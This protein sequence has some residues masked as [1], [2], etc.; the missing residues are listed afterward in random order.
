[1]FDPKYHM[2]LK[3]SACDTFSIACGQTSLGGSN[4][5]CI[6]MTVMEEECILYP[7][8]FTWPRLKEVYELPRCNGGARV[9]PFVYHRIDW[10]EWSLKVLSRCC[11][12][13]LWVVLASYAE[14]SWLDVNI[15]SGN[16]HFRWCCT[17][18]S[19]RRWFHVINKYCNLTIYGW[20]CYKGLL[21]WLNKF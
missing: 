21:F 4:N 3:S 8:H 2:Y 18:D 5:L 11:L 1:M 20:K 9:C 7:T 13:H 16:C 10:V 6:P 19:N 17:I 12:F 14:Q 15:S